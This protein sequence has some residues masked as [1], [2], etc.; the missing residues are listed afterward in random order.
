M[1]VTLLLSLSLQMQQLIAR[2]G[3]I[4]EY[5][6]TAGLAQDL[7]L[8]IIQEALKDLSWEDITGAVPGTA[9]QSHRIAAIHPT[10]WR[11]G[12]LFHMPN[13]MSLKS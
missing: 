5:V 2:R 6:L 12:K 3:A 8:W 4:P 9:R 13:H 7:D 1:L 10:K 11:E